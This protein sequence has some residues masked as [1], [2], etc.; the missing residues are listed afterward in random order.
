M[1]GLQATAPESAATAG[2]SAQPEGAGPLPLSHSPSPSKPKIPDDALSVSDDSGAE[3]S[4]WI[5]ITESSAF[6]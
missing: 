6:S 1:L 3:V 5:P 4:F 2:G